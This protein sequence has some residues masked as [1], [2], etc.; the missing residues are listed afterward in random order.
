MEG[1]SGA[2]KENIIDSLKKE[3][4]IINCMCLCLF[5]SQAAAVIPA[6]WIYIKVVVVKKLVVEIRDFLIFWIERF[7]KWFFSLKNNADLFW[8]VLFI[9]P[10]TNLSVSNNLD[11][12]F[13]SI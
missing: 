12:I 3:D 1:K 7:L 10:W 2:S 5:V 8:S 6:P 9:L 11:L 4:F 13:E